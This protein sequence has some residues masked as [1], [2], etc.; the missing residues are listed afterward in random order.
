[1]NRIVWLSVVLTV[2]GC[3][4]GIPPSI[5]TYAGDLPSR[6]DGQYASLDDLVKKQ[7]VLKDALLQC[8]IDTNDGKGAESAACHCGQSTSENWTDDCKDWLGSHVPQP[9]AAVATNAP[10]AQPPVPEPN[11]QQPGTP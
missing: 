6:A 2:I 11:P 10:P 8:S 7:L 4:G 3:G 9:P 1:M 5:R